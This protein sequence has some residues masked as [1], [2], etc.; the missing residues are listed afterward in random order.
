MKTIL[1]YYSL[2]CSLLIISGCSKDNNPANSD[3]QSIIGKWKILT[4][5]GIDISSAGGTYDI[6]ETKITESWVIPSCTKIYSYTKNGN[7]YTT[8]LQSTTCSIQG[9]DPS[10]VPGYKATGTFTVNGNKLTI[11]LEKGTVV[12]CQRI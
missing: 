6:I 5:N 7:Q 10:N 4:T 8:I 9:N 2:F 3:S 11:T 1:I 12:V